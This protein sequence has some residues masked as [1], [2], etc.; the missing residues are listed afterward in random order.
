MQFV[1]NQA[2]KTTFIPR[3]FGIYMLF[4]LAGY[5]LFGRGFAYL[6]V[7]PIFV[8]EIGVLLAVAALLSGV[9]QLL[10]RSTVTWL[11][12]IFV[13][14]GAA[15]TYP[16][17]S[18]Y[19][20]DSLR[21]GVLWGY[22]I[23]SLAVASIL[24]RFNAIG[25]IVDLYRI[26]VPVFLLL[27]LVIQAMQI[28]AGN[29]IPRW[30]WGAGGEGVPMIETKPGD[31]A[32]NL[33]GIFAFIAF[34]VSTVQFQGPCLFLWAVEA[35]STTLSRGA[36]LTTA[37]VVCLAPLLYPTR[38]N[39]LIILSIGGCL[40][41]AYVT[42]FEVDPGN[43]GIAIR[44]R[45]ISVEH[46]LSSFESI[47]G[48]SSTLDL[49]GTKRWRELWWAKIFDYTFSGEYFWTGKG[50]G[51]NLAD[52]DGFQVNATRSLRSPHNVHMTILARAGVPGLVLWVTLQT[53]FGLMLFLK[54]LKDK[55]AK[56]GQ[57]ARIEAWILLYWLAFLVNASFDVAL[58]GPQ[59]G[60][61]FWSVFGFG[62]ALIVANEGQ[63]SGARITKSTVMQVFP[64]LP[65]T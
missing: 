20:L 50:F 58:E 61:W 37:C 57:L 9:Y 6:G 39:F 33:S 10:W 63:D 55:R 44:R 7:P 26:A 19:G 15:R 14:W 31:L 54:F 13:L 30:P 2:R 40:G 4:L 41:L 34:G 32:V 45:T 18:E 49:E 1:G 23:Y 53:A 64:N 24:L 47:V 21:D 11:L 16:Y 27:I 59:A 17:V 60:I 46:L 22:A 3:C 52:D 43:G 8:G 56:R 51:I 36:L 38:R 65:N 48:T 25:R 5:A 62:L 42:G 12:V 29:S 28:F 35:A